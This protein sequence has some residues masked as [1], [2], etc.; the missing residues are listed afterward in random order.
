MAVM[1][2]MANICLL[3][4][5]IKLRVIRQ[6]KKTKQIIK[7]DSSELVDSNDAYCVPS[8]SCAFEGCVLQPADVCEIF[9]RETDHF[10]SWLMFR[11]ATSGLLEALK[12]WTGPMRTFGFDSGKW[13]A[14]FCD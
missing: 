8:S 11:P 2:R 9:E 10:A 6:K 12:F 7:G 4:E 5:V 13:I 14:L 3:P 1:A